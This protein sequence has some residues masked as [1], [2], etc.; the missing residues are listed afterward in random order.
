[1]NFAGLVGHLY[2]T[3]N[4][5]FAFHSLLKEGYFNKLC[6]DI[7]RNPSK[8]LLDLILVLCHLFCRFPLRNYNDQKFLDEVVH[9]STSIVI[10]PPLPIEAEGILRQHNEDTLD[11]FRAYVET[12]VYQH[13]SSV[14]DDTLPF[15]KHKFGSQ[16]RHSRQISSA[17]KCLPPTKLRSPFSALSGFTDKFKSIHEL[18]TTVRS[19]VFLEESTV[20]YIP[21][22][23]YDTNWVPWNAYI[24]DFFK[25]GNMKALV[26]D[27]KIKGGD[28]WFHLKD[29]SLVL[30]TITA[31]LSNFFGEE[32]ADDAAMI[33]IQDVGGATEDESDDSDDEQVGTAATRGK[34]TSSSSKRKARGTAVPDSWED[35]IDSGSQE[36][37]DSFLDDGSS[38]SAVGDWR[39][40]EEELKL[41]LLAFQCLKDEF[42]T[43]FKKVW[44]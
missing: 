4:A 13:L 39:Y 35:A 17:L 6:K 24:Y 16:G 21:I 38:D 33:D 30:S 19:D 32:I 37:G 27:N 44:A 11:I 36:E 8:V 29:F 42:E 20:P 1:L 43:K 12:Y 25:H 22:Y 26:D 14:S 28:V 18:C 9:P 31:S 2:F 34:S 10:L 41:V 3:E 40:E 5:V 23:P 15:T 7:R